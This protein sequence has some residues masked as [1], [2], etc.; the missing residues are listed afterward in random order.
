[1]CKLP[2]HNH[3]LQKKRYLR[4]CPHVS[5]YFEYVTL[6]FQIQKFPCPHVIG[7]VAD[8]LFYTLQRGLKNI[9]NCWIHVDRSGIQKEKEL[10]ELK[11]IRISVDR[12]NSVNKLINICYLASH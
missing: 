4:P 2:I 11:N 8:L 9:W 12:T 1:M 10:N 5:G 6:S 7:F 3:K